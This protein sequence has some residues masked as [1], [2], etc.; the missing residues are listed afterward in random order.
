MSSWIKILKEVPGLKKAIDALVAPGASQSDTVWYNLGKAV[1][2]IAAAF[3]V[4]VGLEDGELKEIS[5]VIPAILT[6]AGFLFD[7]VANIRL[8]M[9]TTNSLK[10]K[11]TE[12]SK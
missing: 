2:G 9:K 8:R 1:L 12:E 4:Y 7:T 5:A 11:T 3:G 10:D 6:G